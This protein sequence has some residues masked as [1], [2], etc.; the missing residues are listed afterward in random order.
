MDVRGFEDKFLD[1]IEVN[2][3]MTMGVA[4][5][6][7]A[8]V[9]DKLPNVVHVVVARPAVPDTVLVMMVVVAVLVVMVRYVFLQCQ[10]ILLNSGCGKM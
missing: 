5:G 9:V 4:V 3:V 1:L 6:K 7:L 8:T 10:Q 2:L